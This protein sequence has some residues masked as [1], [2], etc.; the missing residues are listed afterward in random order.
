MLYFEGVSD[1]G[2]DCILNQDYIVA[3]TLSEDKNYKNDY[4]LMVMDGNGA[5]LKTGEAAD[6]VV[7]PVKIA[8]SVIKRTLKT[9]YNKYHD[10]FLKNPLPFLEMSFMAANTAIGGCVMAN[11]EMFGNFGACIT[12]AFIHGKNIVGLH[13]GN[14]RAYILRE[15]KKDKTWGLVQLTRDH[16][17]AQDMIDDGTLEEKDYYTVPEVQQITSGIGV[18]NAPQFMPFM[19]TLTHD[20]MLILSTKGLHYKLT[21]KDIV[22]AIGTTPTL[23]E[24]LNHMVAELKRL[25]YPDNVSV[26]AAFDMTKEDLERAQKAVNTT[27]E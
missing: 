15:N 22:E 7:Q 21:S 11:E 3:E 20:Q 4:I 13:C 17:V 14:T 10:E 12:A 16:T 8:A 24:G 25:Q 2:F 23:K 9:V 1:I 27:Y 6:M 26:I 18:Y 5:S 19:H